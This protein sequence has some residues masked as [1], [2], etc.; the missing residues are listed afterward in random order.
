MR[1]GSILKSIF[2]IQLIIFINIACLSATS[3]KKLV[4]LGDS[5]TEGIG[6]AKDLTFGALLQEKLNRNHKKWTI[7]N[8]GISGS[9]TASVVTRMKW[10][11][12]SKPDMIFIEMGANDALRG[13]KLE[14]TKKNLVDAI[15][16]AKAAMVKVVLAGMLAPPNY[17]KD[18]T[19]NFSK[20]YQEIAHE[21]K[22]L[23]IPFLLEGVA[24][25]KELNLADG[26][27]PNEKGHQLIAE[28]VYKFLSEHL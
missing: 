19:K 11:L 7:V 15:K 17:G 9:T 14:M 10:V 8:A 26:I 20:M 18:Y 16:L 27:H 6:V 12:K 25:H 2:I 22:I 24:G 3:S 13:F 28:T 5:I 21:E 4:L 23:F 1:L